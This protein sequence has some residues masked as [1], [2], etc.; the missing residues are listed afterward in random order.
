MRR[1]SLLALLLA[2]PALG[3][4]TL[5]SYRDLTPEPPPSLATAAPSAPAGALVARFYGDGAVPRAD[6]AAALAAAPGDPGLHEIAGYDALLRADDHEAFGHFLA[7]AADRGA[8]APELYLWEMRQATHTMTERLRAQALL[9][10]LAEQHPKPLLRQLAAYELA[11]ELRLVGER[12]EATPLLASLGFLDAWQVAGAFDNDQGKG[13]ATAYPPEEDA[14]RTHTYPGMRVPVRFRPLAVRPTDGALPL[15]DAVSPADAAVAYAETFVHADGRLKVDLRLTTS[16]GVRVWLNGKQVASDERILHEALD[17]VIVRLSLVPGDNR[18]LVKSAHERGPWHLAARLTHPTTGAV[19]R[20]RASRAGQAVSGGDG[21]QVSPF[22]PIDR[23]ADARRKRFLLARAS[24]WVGHPRRAPYYLDPLRHEVPGN[25]LVAYFSA[26]SLR[27]GG[28]VGKALDVLNEGVTRHPTATAFLVERGQF[29]ARRKLWSK[30]QRDLEAALAASPGSHDAATGMA[31]VEAGRGWTMERCQRLDG[32]VQRFPDDVRALD[33]LGGCREDQQLYEEAERLRRRA[34][35]LAPGWLHVLERLHEL[36][37]R[38]LDHDAAA[39]WLQELEAS[40]PMTLAYLLDE[41]ELHRRAGRREASRAALQRA[42]E[43]SPDAPRPYERLGWLAYETGDRAG[44]ERFLRQALERDP[45]NSSLAQR[46]AALSPDRVSA[47]DKLVASADD[48]E[49]AVRSADKVEVHPGSHSVVLLDD[50][51]TTV[52][53]DGSSKRVVT[54]VTQA[55]T[56]EGRDAI[57]QAHLPRG[58]VTVLDA[59]SLRKDGERQEA[60]SIADGLVRFRGLEVGSITVLQYVHYAPPPRFLPNEYVEQWRFQGVS[61]QIESSRWWLVLP[62]ERALNVELRGP[63]EQKAEVVGEQKIWSFS[64]RKAPPLMPEPGMAPAGDAL[65]S[66]TVSTVK[67]WDAYVRWENA[68]LG[69]AFGPSAEIDALARRLT[70][71]ARTPRE[72]IDRLWAYAAQEIRY[73]QEYE[74][75]IAGVKPHS[76]AVVRER[77]YGDCK[78][79]AVLLIR[80]ARVVGVEMRFAL[81]RTRPYGQVQRQIPNQQFNHAIVHVPKQAGI[82]EAFFLDATTNGLD[83][84]NARTDDEGASSLVID[85]LTGRWEFL[86]IPYQPAE[87]E[88]VKH[89]FEIKLADPGKAPA[90]DHFEV[91]G[92]P[93][94]GMRVS[95][96]NKEGAKKFFHGLTDRLFPGAAV[97]GS[98]SEHAQDITR[99]ATA[100]LELD[101]AGALQPEDQLYRLDVP[102]LFPLGGTITLAERR[103]P[104]VLAR[105]TQ[106][107]EIDAELGEGQEASHLP[108]DFKV[109]HACFTVERTTEAKGRH[110]VV[111]QSYRNTCPE[112]APADY[113]A[114]RAAVQKA[115]AHAKDKI[116]FG[117]RGKAKKSGR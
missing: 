12:D 108:A 75:T 93:A 45:D 90:R 74:D 54:T 81:L 3:C 4:A 96:R 104:L 26:V 69:E 39:G 112:I 53:P 25:P 47:A 44:A 22:G 9:R 1:A 80:L 8:V 77:G 60:S 67:D 24:A 63:V 38:R 106:S 20:L 2:L 37:L 65:W 94:A 41:A 16:S 48:L 23:L 43:L 13:F 88:H 36:S 30:A 10:Q 109:E 73:Q 58:K 17:N 52:N 116:V 91:R 59:Y 103:Q 83:V 99:R 85:P 32:L 5:P 42:R 117:P 6:L 76:A 61:A 113:A 27:E 92:N 62:R 31:A 101:L 78:D 28:E 11:R 79:K 115:A 110:V 70:E 87:L 57:L 71:G 14:D 107:I 114:Y 29:Y 19:L 64:T 68:L 72:K 21:Q 34:H 82:D 49:R 86:P 97:T 102:L 15:G 111:R 35:A 18:I 84:G 66:A 98:K 55:V 56:T 100:D 95:L 50:E 33:E 7:A 51:V 40:H 46:L 105:G 89:R